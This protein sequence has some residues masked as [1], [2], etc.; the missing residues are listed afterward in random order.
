[1]PWTTAEEGGNHE[2][3]P[4]HGSLGAPWGGLRLSPLA[5]A[6]TASMS[7]ALAPMATIEHRC[8]HLYPLPSLSV[9][10]FRRP[11]RVICP[12]THPVNRAESGSSLRNYSLA[13]EH[14]ITNTNGITWARGPSDV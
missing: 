3:W 5:D 1:M 14:K 8:A 13:H 7:L 4:V 11:Q 12:G 10:F 9:Y 2:E 6:P